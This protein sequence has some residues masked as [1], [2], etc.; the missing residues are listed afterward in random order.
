MSFVGTLLPVA[1][2]NVENIIT[3]LL[4]YFTLSVAASWLP[5]A[6]AS[7]LEKCS[8]QCDDMRWVILIQTAKSFHFIFHIEHSE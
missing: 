2:G 1:L 7:N 3:I 4:Q 5:T 8:Q 6:L